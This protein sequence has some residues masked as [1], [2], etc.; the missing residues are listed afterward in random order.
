MPILPN[1]TINTSDNLSI[2]RSTERL[3]SLIT[4]IDLA[5]I[6][7]NANSPFEPSHQCCRTLS[8]KTQLKYYF[9]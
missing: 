7:S 2:T 1:P 5:V 6:N 9:Y 4:E 3:N 8:E